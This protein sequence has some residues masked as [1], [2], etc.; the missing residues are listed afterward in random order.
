MCFEITHCRIVAERVIFFSDVGCS[1]APWM[2]RVTEELRQCKQ[3][4]SEDA[5]SL[6]ALRAEAKQY[7]TEASLYRNKLDEAKKQ[8][9]E[10]S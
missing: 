5:P 4:Q 7:K 1:C 3:Q 8:L 10:V 6:A 2:H 9:Q